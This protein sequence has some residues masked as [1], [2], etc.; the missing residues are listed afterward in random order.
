MMMLLLTAALIC[1][2]SAEVKEL[3]NAE[4]TTETIVADPEAQ[5]III[6]EKGLETQFKLVY[7]ADVP[8][9]VRYNIFQIRDS[10]E[11]KL[12]VNLLPQDQF[13]EEEGC[14]ILIGANRRKEYTELADTLRKGE[15]A[16]KVITSEADNTQILLA[17]NGS[18]ARMAVIDRFITEY[19]TD[20]RAAVPANLDIKG[21]CG[22]SNAIITSSIPQQRDP[23]VIVVDGVYYSYGTGWFCMKNTSGKL[24][25]Y[26]QDIGRVVQ[27]PEDAEGDYWAPEVHVYNGS[28][29]MFTTY[30]SA[31]TGHR[32]CTI[33]KSDS[34]EGPFVEITDGHI[35]PAD[36]DSIDGTFYVDED[37]QP[38]MIFVHE[39]TSMPDHVGRMA[40]AKLSDDLTEFISEPIDL[41]G[42]K[43]PAWAKNG[44]TDGCWMYKCE[45]GELLMIWSN[46]DAAGYCVGIARSDN[47]KVDGKWTQDK[48]LLYSKALTDSYD[49][50]HGM[51]FTDTDGQM[52][53]SIHSPNSSSDSQKEKPTFIPIKERDGTLVWD[54]WDDE[55]KTE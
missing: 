22:Q 27:V 12:G 2:C 17:Y 18:F 26:W 24:D 53:L 33:M 43:D 35:T 41:F 48:P 13:F 40:A 11:K 16:I 44:V 30:R 47:G 3:K 37:G 39:W 6:A 29:Y 5:E 46:S 55:Q 31:K 51:I 14:E 32:G 15:Y 52:Y 42:A 36:W 50:G 20:E 7:N 45:T 23:C 25:G 9:A 54:L 8:Y 38:W 19:I 1:S 34:P 28:Y 21:I 10:V 49:G 4:S